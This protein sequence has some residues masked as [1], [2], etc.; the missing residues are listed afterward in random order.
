MFLKSVTLKGFKSF[1]ETTVVDFDPGLTVV[2]G[3]NGTGKSNI[4]ESISW[5][6]GSQSPTSMRSDQMQDVIF[7]GSPD[8]PPLGRAEVTLTLGNEDGRLPI[9]FPEVAL[10]RSLFRSG[11]SSYA[12]NGT[13][14]RLVDIAELLAAAGVGRH[15]HVIVS[16]GRIDAM[17]VAKPTERRAIL[18][19]AAGVSAFRLRKEKA[20]RRLAA[21]EANLVRLGDQLREVRRQ[22]KPLEEQAEAAR[23][24]GDLAAELERLRV[25]VLAEEFRVLN[26]RRRKAAAHRRDLADLRSARI[27]HSEVLEKEIADAERKLAE[28]SPVELT[29]SLERSGRLLG[30]LGDV[31]RSLTRKLAVLEQRRQAALSKDVLSVLTAEAEKLRDALEGEDAEAENLREEIAGLEAAS[32]EL[33]ERR[34]GF[35]RSRNERTLVDSAVSDA[36]ALEAKSAALSEVLRSTEAEEAALRDRCEVIRGQCRDAS[37]ERERLVA[38]SAELRD[39]VSAAS[40]AR[41]AETARCESAQ[42]AESEALR[43]VNE[44]RIELA[45]WRSRS[46][47]LSK[48]RPVT[49]GLDPEFLASLNGLEGILG[50][51][52]S[53]ETG[54]E[55]AFEAAVGEFT[56]ALVVEGAD[57]ARAVFEALKR[58]GVGGIVLPVLPVASRRRPSV[59]ESLKEHVRVAE[60]K[61]EGLA[62]M[63]LGGVSVVDDWSQAAEALAV[64]PEAVF[65]TRQGE[66]LSARGWRLGSGAGG[67]RWGG[68]E[69]SEI[70][71][72]LAEAELD[73]DDKQRELSAAA[74][75]AL[76]CADA[77]AAAEAG[78]EEANRRDAEV[79]ERTSSVEGRLAALQPELKETTGR[80]ASTRSGLERLREEVGSLSERLEERRSLENSA[81]AEAEAEMR[82]LSDETAEMS[83]RQKELAVRLAERETRRS[84]FGKRLAEIDSRL[85]EHGKT[86]GSSRAAAD[87]ER[88]TAFGALRERLANKER[89]MRLNLER[90]RS[91]QSRLAHFSRERLR[92]LETERLRRNRLL[93][94]AADLVEKL[95]AAERTESEL[96]V[97]CES[98]AET[99]HAQHDCD[100]A[101]AAGMPPP[102]LPEGVNAQ[103]RIREIERLLSRIGEINPLAEREYASLSGHHDFLSSQVD[104]V[105]DSKRELKKVIRAIDADI[106]KVFADFYEKVAG[107]FEQC[108]STLFEGGTGR[109]R[110]TEPDDP[111]ESGVEIEARP[112]GKYMRRLALLS[113]GERSLTAMALVFALLRSQNSPFFVLDEVDAALDDANLCRF[114][115]LTEEFRSEVQLLMISHQKRTMEV[116]DCLLGVSMPSGGG[117]R[118]V[119]ERPS[120]ELGRAA[121]AP[122]SSVG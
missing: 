1:A 79:R 14:A 90:M 102:E 97:R 13:P 72:S 17:L 11:E 117:S 39:E 24:H 118:V 115:R 76:R 40:V 103:R 88:I 64:H 49:A 48:A 89:S 21:A 6:L 93:Q 94:E 78:L 99:L 22:L 104:D 67:A 16:Q 43:Q 53:P 3:P 82:A 33:T 111:L 65:V 50:D 23:R 122:L 62:E 96:S 46:E 35:E 113:G 85:A 91:L 15:R 70:S 25:Y 68:W 120:R 59:G 92:S 61:V 55:E 75:E 51:L 57:A 74:A 4:V 83:N 29:R 108:F 28:S 58:E 56:S 5:V 52:L 26:D 41:E 110:L 84:L 54:W 44:A 69:E 19:E 9:D 42:A 47:A 87:E 32:A 71:E 31:E 101:A 95:L 30:L 18:E 114:L 37:E 105:R 8:R 80:L 10:S 27:R 36:R 112:G 109:L 116:A 98:L 77:S 86:L 7:S 119:S 81:R 12:I 45:L 60:E 38:C 107:A 73:L 20:L 66:C 2:V 121:P 63:I 34:T 100:P 106:V